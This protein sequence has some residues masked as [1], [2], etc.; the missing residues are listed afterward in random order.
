MKK[1]II[2]VVGESGAGKDTIVNNAIQLSKK[3]YKNMRLKPIVSYTTRPKR[4]RETDGVE[5]YFIS[6]EKAHELLTTQ[7]IIAYTKIHD[8]TSGVEGFEY[9]ATIENIGDSN[10][11]IIDPNG[12]A[13]L[14][15]YVRSGDIDISIIYIHVPSFIRKLRSMKRHDDPVAYKNRVMNEKRQFKTF[16][17]AIRC[18]A[19]KNAHV[20]LN[21]SGMQNKVT[22]RFCA[23]AK[24]FLE[25]DTENV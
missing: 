1:K 11:Y 24:K 3:E 19:Y 9:F 13:Y 15:K 4:E 21:I 23:I 22:R 18:G 17:K 20:L 8:K 10:I 14:M 5:H 16:R 2:C 25:E 12:I 7:Q 6:T